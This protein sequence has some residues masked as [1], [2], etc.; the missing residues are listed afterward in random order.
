MLYFRIFRI[1]EIKIWRL[2][3]TIHERHSANTNMK[4]IPAALLLLDM[5][6]FQQII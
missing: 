4:K 6:Y 5:G 3:H 1:Y 2:Q